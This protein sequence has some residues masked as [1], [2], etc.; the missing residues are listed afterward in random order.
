[1]TNFNFRT[2]TACGVSLNLLQQPVYVTFDKM[3]YHS[4]A[5]STRLLH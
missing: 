2:K 1:M 3:T 4:K 5:I